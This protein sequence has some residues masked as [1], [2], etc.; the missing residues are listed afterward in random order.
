L[1]TST[2]G[3]GVGSAMVTC[4][5]SLLALTYGPSREPRVSAIRRSSTPQ[6]SRIGRV[7][8]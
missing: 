2:A 5:C 1:C 6:I 3:S 8:D 7:D 4:H